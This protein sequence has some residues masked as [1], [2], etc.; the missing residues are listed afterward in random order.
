M[1]VE[2]RILL[3]RLLVLQNC[4][5]FCVGFEFFSS[6]MDNNRGT[7]ILYKDFSRTIRNIR[8]QAKTVDSN[9]NI[10]CISHVRC[11]DVQLFYT[12]RKCSPL[13][14]ECNATMAANVH[15]SCL[16]GTCLLCIN[17]LLYITDAFERYEKSHM[18]A[19]PKTSNSFYGS[20]I[21]EAA[22]GSPQTLWLLEYK[23]TLNK[24]EFYGYFD[25]KPHAA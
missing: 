23:C 9:F 4:L 22:K 13:F 11:Y 14:H 12:H 24:S 7:C 5:E 10:L 16:F 8:T 18:F 21:N 2:N 25:L 3:K 20:N 15:Y 19:V 1:K 17:I 6:A